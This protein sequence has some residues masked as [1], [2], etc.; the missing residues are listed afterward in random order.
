MG[1]EGDAV[2]HEGHGRPELLGVGS[3]LLELVE[4]RPAVQ[5]WCL[6]ALHRFREA[7]V[8]DAACCKLGHVVLPSCISRESS[9]RYTE[10]CLCG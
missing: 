3:G 5:P 9:P 6:V 1:D 8:V 4:E 2:E 10:L 7:F